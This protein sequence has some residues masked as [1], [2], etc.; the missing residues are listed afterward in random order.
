MGSSTEATRQAARKRHVCSICGHYIHVGTVYERW[1][2][3]NSDGAWVVKVHPDCWDYFQD[4]PDREWIVGDTFWE[5][6]T[7]WLLPKD[8]LEALNNFSDEALR[9]ALLD[10]YNTRMKDDV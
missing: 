1:R 8:A 3:F 9:A 5:H 4:V 10:D 6:L 7:G 2:Y